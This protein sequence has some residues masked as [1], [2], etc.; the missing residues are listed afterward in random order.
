MYRVIDMKR[1]LLTLLFCLVSAGYAY[2]ATVYAI[3]GYYESGASSC[4]E[5]TDA[6]T[7]GDLEAAL[8]AA[9]VGGALYIC[10]GTYTTTEIDAADGLDSTAANQ[11]IIGVGTVIL[12]G[13]DIN[14]NIITL[15]HDA[16]IVQSII[17]QNSFVGKRHYRTTAG[18]NFVVNDCTFIMDSTDTGIKVSGLSITTFN[19][20][21]FSGYNVVGAYFPVQA[22]GA[23]VDMTFNYCVFS[24]MSSGL[25]VRTGAMTFNN[26]V[27]SGIK[28]SALYLYQNTDVKILTINNSIFNATSYSDNANTINNSSTGNE[29]LI[30]SDSYITPSYKNPSL[31]PG[32]G[33]AFTDGGGNIFDAAPMF[34]RQRRPFIFVFEIDDFSNIDEFQRLATL[35]EARGW[36]GTLNINTTAVDA[37]GWA[38]L[39]SLADSGHEIASHTRHHAN[40]NDLRAMQVQYVGAAG[41]CDMTINISTNALSTTEGLSLTLSSYANTGTLCTAID[42]YADY[43]CTSGAMTPDVPYAESGMATALEDIAGQDIKTAVYTISYDEIRHYDEEMTGSKNDI[44]NNLTGVTVTTLAYPGNHNSAAS[45]AGLITRGYTGARTENGSEDK[46]ESI[47]VY[48]LRAMELENYLDTNGEITA[49]IERLGFVGGVYAAYTHNF[50]AFSEEEFEAL[51]DAIEASGGLVM[52]R[53]QAVEY[54]KA[55][56]TTAD[57]ITYTRTFTDESDYRLQPTSPAINTGTTAGTVS[58]TGTQSDYFGN[59]YFFAPYDRLNIGADQNHSDADNRPTGSGVLRRNG[60]F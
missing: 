2:S 26:C 47:N 58:L 15:A 3:E 1:I 41:S 9:G 30:I 12:D 39:Q 24:N 25:M 27:F 56:G 32:V 57:D 35:L 53:T 23:S 33:G 52:T 13:T 54:I 44:E 36:R 49:H 42:N 28:S 18:T 29:T 46:M 55:N 60:N 10:P 48:A 34:M 51:F 40:M 43:T 4:D 7:A 11:S 20:C 45:Q 16:V 21:T 59:T 37:A 31:Y 50:V 6:D 14:D 8:A 5:V 17:F 38:A 19:R 22:W